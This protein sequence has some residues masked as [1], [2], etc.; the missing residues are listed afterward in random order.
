MAASSAAARR[1]GGSW[2]GRGTWPR[3]PSAVAACRHGSTPMYVEDACAVVNT[4]HAARLFVSHPRCNGQWPHAGVHAKR[5][6]LLSIAYAEELI[7][8]TL[9]A[10][11]QR[12]DRHHG[13]VGQERDPFQRVVSTASR[14][15]GAWRSAP[16]Y[17]KAACIASAA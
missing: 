13:M 11:L 14:A 1:S 2:S 3:A 9:S 15:S 12:T 10:T 5:D 16:G 6:K 7:F 8:S 4:L 17:A